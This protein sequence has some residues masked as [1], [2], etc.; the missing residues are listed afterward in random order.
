M[1]G[2]LFMSTQK[3]PKQINIYIYIFIFIYL[4]IYLFNGYRQCRRPQTRKSPADGVAEK[5]WHRVFAP[6]L[7]VSEIDLSL[8]LSSGFRV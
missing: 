6:K 5:A 3:R 7:K 8:C 2:L 1:L 4:F